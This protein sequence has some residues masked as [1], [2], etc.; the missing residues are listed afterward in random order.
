MTLVIFLIQ[1]TQR[2]EKRISEYH[3]SRTGQES[4]TAPQSTSGTKSVQNF[5]NL[6]ILGLIKFVKT[7]QPFK[8]NYFVCRQGRQLDPQRTRTK[9]VN[10]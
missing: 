7:R 10:I 1:L 9:Y 5:F 8:R 4:K 2:Y 6:F 3:R